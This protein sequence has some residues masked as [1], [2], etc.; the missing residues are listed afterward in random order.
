LREDWIKSNTVA[1][2]DA[3]SGNGDDDFNFNAE[4]LSGEM[5]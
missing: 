5:V 3:A 1:A 4:S 2:A